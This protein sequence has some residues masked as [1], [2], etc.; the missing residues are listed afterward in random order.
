MSPRRV[1]R[2]RQSTASPGPTGDSVDTARQNGLRWVSDVMPGIKR[3]AH[4]RSFAYSG[5]DGA[6]IRDARTLQRINDLAIPP[7]WTS[8]WICPHERGHVQATGRDARG[9]KQYR[10]HPRWREARDERKYDRMVAFGE[11]LPLIRRRVNRDFK[12]PSLSRE[13]VLATVVRLLDIALIRVGNREY[14]RDNASYGLTT[15]QADQVRLDGSRVRFA[16]RSKSGKHSIVEVED[17]RVARTLR[18]CTTLPG[19]E[20]FQYL[21]DDGQPRPITSDD[22]NAYLR[23]LS[24][25]DFTAKDFRTWA[26]SVL[27]VRALLDHDGHESATEARRELVSAI[28][29]VASQLGNTPAVCRS[30]Y[31]HPWVIDAHLRGSLAEIDLPARRPRVPSI[32]TTLSADERAILGWLQARTRAAARVAEPAL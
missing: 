25:D 11:A 9:R 18:R 23:A 7:A 24:G 12:N 6:D 31:V 19:E 16:F 22:V 2:R 10:Y 28:K 27:T 15:M 30:C 20:L 32:L 13:R 8:V 14:A 5:P 21:G 17:E 4:H 1:P 26:G 3:R 29:A